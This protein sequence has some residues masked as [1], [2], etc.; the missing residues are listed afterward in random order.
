MHRVQ[1]EEKNRPFPFNTYSDFRKEQNLIR[2]QA[3]LPKEA[4]QIAGTFL[5]VSSEHLTQASGTDTQVLN[6]RHSVHVG[7]TLRLTIQALALDIESDSIFIDVIKS[8]ADFGLQ[9]VQTHGLVRAFGKQT[10][11][12]GTFRRDCSTCRENKQCSNMH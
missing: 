6:R 9:T 2:G 1:S 12:A 8:P 10:C 7:D 3:E 11:R 5:D 4:G